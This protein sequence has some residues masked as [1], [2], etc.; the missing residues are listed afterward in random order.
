MTSHA[1]RAGM[2][3]M[4]SADTMAEYFATLRAMKNVG[5]VPHARNRC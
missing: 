5:S 3:T 4:N 1:T 2:A